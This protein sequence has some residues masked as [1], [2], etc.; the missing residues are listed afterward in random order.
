M[1]AANIAEL[2]PKLTAIKIS[3]IVVMLKTMALNSICEKINK[4]IGTITI[5]V[6]KSL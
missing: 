2:I 4:L 3:K 5:K 6:K 1:M